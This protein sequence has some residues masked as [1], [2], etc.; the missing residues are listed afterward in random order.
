MTCN[1]S[2]SRMIADRDL[3]QGGTVG[4]ILYTVSWLIIIFTTEVGSKLPVISALGALI[5]GLATIARLVLSIGFNRIYE[6]LP[7]RYWQRA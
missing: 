5:L 3:S 2:S 7:D 6:R 1:D 4:S